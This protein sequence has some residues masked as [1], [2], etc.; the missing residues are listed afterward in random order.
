MRIQTYGCIGEHLSHSFSK[1]V[2]EKIADYDYQ[3]QELTPDDLGPFLEKRQFFGINVTIPYKEA[4][5]PYLDE[6]DEG[7]KRMQA[8]NTVVN[9]NG[10]LLGFN[11][12]FAGMCAMI[13]KANIQIA[14]KKVL[15]LGTGGTSKTSAAVAGYLGAKKIDKVSRTGKDGALTYEEAITHH[16]DTEIIINTTPCGMFP[17][18][19][20]CPINLDFFPKVTGVIDVIY[21]PLETLLVANARKKGIPGVNGL[22]MLV[23]Q[24]VF[25]S[26]HFLNT[27]YEP[28]L[29]DR[30]YEEVLR[31]KE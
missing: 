20:E 5:I 30:V 10:R 9:R 14:R 19:E 18:G 25:A 26:E 15:I 29:V 23:A 21:N 22:Y 12:D 13:E 4:V 8:V 31:E 24:A 2:H 16:R 28:G 17:H 1:E 6:L 7:A 27:Q 3:I 11:T